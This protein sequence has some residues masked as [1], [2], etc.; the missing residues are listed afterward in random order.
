MSVIGVAVFSLLLLS[1]SPR[2]TSGP[3]SICGI[4]QDQ[5]GAVMSAATVKLNIVDA[6]VKQTTDSKRTILLQPSGT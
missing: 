3:A 5:T 1:G 4:V 6:R 2:Q